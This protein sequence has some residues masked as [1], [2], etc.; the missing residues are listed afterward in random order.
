MKRKAEG[1]VIALSGKTAKVRTSGQIYCES[2]ESQLVGNSSVMDVYNPVAA[3]VGQRVIID[4]PETSLKVAFIV[5]ILPLI[6]TFL[7]FL[8]GVWISQNFGFPALLSEVGASI[9]AL[10]LTLLYIK[11]FDRTKTNM[12]PVIAQIL[13]EKFPKDVDL[14]GYT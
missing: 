6:T 4:L 1:I 10:V 13:P 9:V 11:Y 3:A 12:M 8:T 2:C 14:S 7:G 5:F